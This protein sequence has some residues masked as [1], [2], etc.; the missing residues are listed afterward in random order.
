MK[1]TLLILLVTATIG[2]SQ[3]LFTNS[4]NVI[5]SQAQK[6]AVQMANDYDNNL[7][8][9]GFFPYSAPTNSLTLLQYFSVNSGV[10]F[11]D[12]A[13]RDYPQR[14]AEFLAALRTA[15]MAKR[16][17]ALKAGWLALQ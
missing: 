5:Y 12:K 4:V 6:D 10:A 7:R 11:Q 16:M 17:A 9:N 14:E 8:T 13:E 15:T 3:Q 2:F 1:N